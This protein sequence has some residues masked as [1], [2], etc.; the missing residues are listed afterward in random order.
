MGLR[1]VLDSWIGYEFDDMG[2]CGSFCTS[3]RLSQ[4]GFR[5]VPPVDKTRWGPWIVQVADYDKENA[6]EIRAEI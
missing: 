4:V 3:L 1:V 6:D 5:F 2:E